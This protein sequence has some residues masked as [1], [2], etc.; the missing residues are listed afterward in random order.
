MFLSCFIRT[1]RYSHFFPCLLMCGLSSDLFHWVSLVLIVWVLAYFIE[2]TSK[3]NKCTI[4]IS[5]SSVL[6]F[7]NKVW[8]QNLHVSTALGHARCNILMTGT[9]VLSAVGA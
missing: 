4:Y 2:L 1:W 5:T 8:R 6:Y 3:V 7:W 9:D